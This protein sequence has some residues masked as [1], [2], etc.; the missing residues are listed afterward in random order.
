MGRFQIELLN[1]TS[2]SK[3]VEQLLVTQG[4]IIR[5]MRRLRDFFGTK[6]LAFAA[7]NL[8]PRRHGTQDGMRVSEFLKKQ[9][10]PTNPCALPFLRQGFSQE[11]L[12]DLD[13]SCEQAC[14]S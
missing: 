1:L 13:G 3:L 4:T 2:S 5:G 11:C 8:Y 14:G 7:A 9:H 6:G 10:L 12:R